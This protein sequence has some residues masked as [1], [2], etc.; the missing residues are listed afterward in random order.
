VVIIT[1]YISQSVLALPTVALAKASW[2]R[3]SITAFTPGSTV[4]QTSYASDS[5]SVPSNTG[6]RIDLSSLTQ[7][8]GSGLTIS[9]FQIAITQAGTYQI[10]L[11]A[12]V[13][14]SAVN[15]NPAI[16]C[17]KNGTTVLALAITQL[18]S[19]NPVLEMISFSTTI[20]LAVGDTIDFRCNTSGGI[21][22][23]WAISAN[24]TQIPSS[25]IVPTTTWNAVAGT[26]QVMLANNSYYAQSASL[27]T[28]TLPVSCAVGTIMGIA[29]VGAGGWILAQNA[30]QS[31][32]FGNQVTTT[33]TG[34]S[35]ASSNRYDG[36]VILC[37]VAN[38]Q[39]VVRGAVGNLTVV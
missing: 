30:G 33:G 11:N 15:S 8:E 28:F 27:T 29:G 23:F 25:T 36:L 6:S 34:G 7:N 5:G 19:G 14:V 1:E 2:N 24:I 39:W 32:N 12:S 35:M 31:I 17:V 37:V 10:L 21:F 9:Q 13:Y 16:Q 3:Q 22:S 26:S 18:I 38:T 4:V 20:E